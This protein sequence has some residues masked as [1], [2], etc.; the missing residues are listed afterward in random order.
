MMVGMLARSYPRVVVRPDMEVVSSVGVR[1][2]SLIAIALLSV[3]AGCSQTMP[4][5]AERMTCGY[6]YYLDGA[7]GGGLIS[8]WSGGL[9]QGMLAAGYNG[10]GE[11]FRWN[12]GM[13]VVADQDSSVDY[14]RG[15][16][17]EC[18]A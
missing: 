18:A 17:T 7:G 4:D 15:K 9:R 11:I 3:T 8:N 1:G 14:K 2:A 12:T 5:R 6:V 16:A 10:A 13:G